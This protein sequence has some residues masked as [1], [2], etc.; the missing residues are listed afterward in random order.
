MT[1]LSTFPPC[2]SRWLGLLI[3]T[4]VALPVALLPTSRADVIYL[5]DGLVLEGR[6]FKERD[7]ISDP[8]SGDVIPIARANGFYVL[9]EGARY[10]IFNPRMVQDVESKDRRSDDE[11]LIRQARR[12]RTG[13]LPSAATIVEASDFDANWRRVLKIDSPMGPYRIEQAVIV[14]TPRFCR[15]DALDY[16]WTTYFLTQEVGPKTARYLLSKHPELLEKPGEPVDYEKRMR[17]YRFMIQAKWYDAAEAELDLL[18]KDLPTEKAKIDKT[19]ASLKSLRYEAIV[20]ELERRLANG[21]LELVRRNLAVLPAQGLEDRLGARVTILKSKVESMTAQLAQAKRHLE[22]LREQVQGP[23]LAFLREAADTIAS[24]LHHETVERLDAFVTLSEQAERDRKAEKT[25]AQTPEQLLALAVSGWLQGKNA[26][27]TQVELARKLWRARQ[28]ILDYTRTRDA[29]TRSRAYQQYTESKSDQVGIDELTQMIPLLPPPFAEEKFSTT[30]PMEL[31]VAP[32]NLNPAGIRYQLA[33]PPEYS[34]HRPYSVLFVLCHGSERFRDIFARFHD[35]AAA[36]GYILIAP[37]WN[38]LRPRYNYEVS[39][40]EAITEVLRDVRRRFNVDSDRVFLFGFGEGAT[41]ALDVGLS[42]PDLFAGVVPM[43]PDP[44]WSLLM[45]Y[46]RNAQHLPMYVITGD[47]AGDAPKVLRRGLEQW[48]P[49]GHPVLASIYKG[50]IIE[51][52]AGE[53]PM[54]FEWMSKRKRVAYPTMVGRNPAAGAFG[55]GLQILR[56]EDNRFYWLSTSSI[57]PANLMDIQRGRAAVPAWMQGT[58][59]D[60]SEIWLY[61]H[62]L[63]QISV[64]LGPGMVNFDVPLKVRING[65]QIVGMNQPVRR[66]LQ[67]LLEDL[68]DR[69]DRQR[70]FWA[71]L[72]FPVR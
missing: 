4:L 26:A 21:S 8:L 9:D 7:T 20:E 22:S 14:L 60:A 29:V 25:P 27:S 28:F 66:D 58:I 62:G 11:I 19:R 46:W 49:K 6:V 34:H 69:Q 32:T 3:L 48:M 53:I 63:R 16:I 15:V 54:I 52:F 1:M 64:W 70:L 72:D 65:A 61:T 67:L 30:E 40:H 10:F 37:D 55:E 38:G 18:A 17:I 36:H 31:K 59:K 51:W 39:E 13:R 33:L 44:R 35:V 57:N 43:G 41:M 12:I 45:H 23:A 47:L 56:E 68:Q 50:R 71:K 42:K 5:K 2:R 24:E